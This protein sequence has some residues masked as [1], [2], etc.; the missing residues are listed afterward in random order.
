MRTPLISAGLL[1][2]AGSAFGG[3]LVVALSGGDYTS[4]QAALDA[5]GPGDRVLVR[6]RSGGWNEKVVFTNGGS[7]AGGWLELMAF[8]GESPA[9][10]GTGVVGEWM[11]EISNK[12]YV[13]VAGFEIRNNLGT[14]GDG[15]GIRL[16]GQGSHYIF[17]GNVIHDM[18]GDD[19]MA[20]TVYGTSTTGS[21]ADL[22]IDGNLVYDCE[23]AQSEAIT[24]NGNVE[25]FEVTNNFVRDVN[26]I[27]I[28]FIGGEASI[29]PLF[30]AR[31]G[32]V[33]G[34]RV[35]RANANY[36]GGFGAG[37]YVD[38]GK[39][40]L[41][42]G[43]TVIG[44][45]LGIEVGAENAGVDSSGIIVRQN[46]IVANDKA[47]LVFGGFDATVGRVRDCVF[48]NN[49]LHSNDTLAIGVGEIWVQFAENC[50][51]RGNLVVAGPQNIWLYGETGA[52]GITF[53][54]NQYSVAAGQG[55]FEWDGSI[56]HFADWRTA[57]GNDASSGLGAPLFI[58]AFGPD[59]VLGTNDDNFGLQAGSP[60]IDAGD[61]GALDPLMLEDAAGGARFASSPSAAGG[62]SGLAPLVDRGPLEFVD[63]SAPVLRYCPS[64]PNSAG[65]GAW[66]GW[67][68]SLSVAANVLVLEARDL[69]ASQFGLFF[70]GSSQLE[71]TSGNGTLCVGGG[72]V[73]LSVV[74]SDGL[75][76]AS[77]PVDVRAQGQGALVV[78]AT[79]MFQHWTRDSTGMGWNFSD[80]LLLTFQP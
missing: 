48:A 22:V 28:D 27:G 1:F 70:H 62:G 71:V 4:I 40:I 49:L 43:N 29:N 7:A 10:D 3:D 59:G 31:D 39:D 35:E 2:L 24:L 8:P 15:S 36:G 11:I 45:D 25:R 17:E 65:A 51:L 47:G 21:I 46:L 53:D 32:V 38:G 37:I 23:P 75:G 73:R 50:D 55:M 77:W 69:P 18:R 78:G 34:N 72:L 6:E 58:D 30:V 19:A 42:E 61:N 16:R 52:P 68:G 54:F 64:S 12:S 26:N 5:A 60:A 56:Y 76:A 33:R 63:V 9:L 66:M 67:S 57:T 14:Q 20:I 13:R 41:I 74:A 44:C 79:R 80:G